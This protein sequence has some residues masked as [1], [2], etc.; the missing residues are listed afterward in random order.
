[1]ESMQE[2]I[3]KRRDFVYNNSMKKVLETK[4]V[5]LRE[6]DYT[7]FDDLCEILCDARVMK[8]YEHAFSKEEALDWLKRQMQRYK[9]DGVG[10]W[11]MIRKS[12]QAFLGQCG[13]TVQQ[14]CNRQVYEIGYLLK[15]EHWHHGYARKAA[16]ACREYAFH[17][18][19]LD[20]VYS[21]IRD[22]N[23]ASQKVALANN[24]K[25]IG[26]FV[27]HYYGMVMPHIAYEV[28]NPCL[29]LYVDSEFDAVR[30]AGKH[31]QC[32][33]SLGAV[34]CDFQ[35]NQVTSFYETIR[36]RYFKSL[37]RVVSQITKLTGQEIRS[38]KSLAEVLEHFERWLC[39]Y[40]KQQPVL[41]FSFGPDDKR[42]LNKHCELEKV[43]MPL[44]LQ[45]MQDLQRPLSQS[46][47]YHG[48]VVSPTLSLDAL[49][50]VYGIL[51]KVEH[52]ARSDAL[53]LM[54][55]HHCY[56]AR[57][58]VLE[59]EVLKLVKKREEKAH[60]ARMKQ[61]QKLYQIMK[62]RFAFCSGKVEIR[63]YPEVLQAF[64]TWQSY[65]EQLPLRF[66]KKGVYYEGKM[67]AYD[68]LHMCMYMEWEGELPSVILSLSDGTTKGHVRLLV[69]Y[70]NATLIE[71]I[72]KRCMDC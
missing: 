26:T 32:V 15:Y 55:L 21:I 29:C 3:G 48:N 52:N 22:T 64:A 30:Y 4:R 42:T 67:V 71:T 54:E 70:R 65:D 6:M 34:L 58:P 38:S 66:R 7:D 31:Y 17:T 27:K 61:Q 20:A 5:Y 49:K 25:P 19:K 72:L 39:Q 13:I 45:Y 2:G 12:D 60:A 44:V 10:L 28:K 16:I 47:V 69:N 62:E 43:D 56:Q 36:P 40:Q 9:E 8:A 46:V 24:M 1:M 51:G 23:Y 35:G 41:S 33:I 63:F 50:K 14:L 18:L 11:A 59:E 57:Q 37:T 68:H 53:D